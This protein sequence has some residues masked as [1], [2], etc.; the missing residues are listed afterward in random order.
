MQRLAYSVGSKGP[1]LHFSI[2]TSALRIK[3]W[4]AAK[5]RRPPSAKTL[6]DQQ[7]QGQ[8]HTRLIQ[9]RIGPRYKSAETTNLA[10]LCLPWRIVERGG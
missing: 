6:R 10:I 2:R 4:R 9:T 8:E 5:A 3:G 7:K 1:S